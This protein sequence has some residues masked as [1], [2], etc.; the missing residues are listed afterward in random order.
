MLVINCN[1]IIKELLDLFVLSE[2]LL[3]LAFLFALGS[4]M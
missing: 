4:E 3:E 2:F 1:I